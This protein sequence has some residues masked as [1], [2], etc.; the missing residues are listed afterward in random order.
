MFT[1]PFRYNGT[2][3]ATLSSE[4]LHLTLKGFLSL[5]NHTRDVRVHPIRSPI[6]VS[7]FFCFGPSPDLEGCRGPAYHQPN[8]V[9]RLA[10][11]TDANRYLVGCFVLIHSRIMLILYRNATG[12]PVN[13]TNP[14]GMLVLGY[15]YNNSE[16]LML[17]ECPTQ[18]DQGMLSSYTHV[19]PAA[20]HALEHLSYF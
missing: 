19:A 2:G 17:S 1:R 20:L 11:W 14:I 10:R 8:N 13:Q 3:H 15:L 4:A 7:T 16:N 9:Y 18:S 5:C 6:N 12:L